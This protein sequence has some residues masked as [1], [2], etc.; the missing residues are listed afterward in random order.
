MAGKTTLRQPLKANSIKREQPKIQPRRAD[1]ERFQSLPRMLLFK[2]IFDFFAGSS[3]IQ[4]CFSQVKGTLDDDVTDGKSSEANTMED[5][6]Y[7]FYFSS[8]HHFLCRVQPGWRSFSYGWQRWS[9]RDIPKRS[10]RKYFSIAQCPKM[11]LFDAYIFSPHLPI[12]VQFCSFFVQI[13]S[14]SHF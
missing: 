12:L 7:F 5:C 2:W 11:L 4:W 14:F 8:R 10:S 13:G 6:F 1:L 9:G 3:D